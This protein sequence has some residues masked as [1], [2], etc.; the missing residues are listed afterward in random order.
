MKLQA[1]RPLKPRKISA[2]R[3]ETRVLCSTHPTALRRERLTLWLTVTII[4]VTFA[5][6]AAAPGA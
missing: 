2:A 3:A 5:S 4:P 6:G 1:S